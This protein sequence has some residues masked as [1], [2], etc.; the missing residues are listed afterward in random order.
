ME[1]RTDQPSGQQQ[2]VGTR[3]EVPEVVLHAL[4]LP[5]EEQEELLCALAPRIVPRLADTGRRDFISGLR[6]VRIEAKLTTPVPE[7]MERAA[8]SADEVMEE[9]L[10]QAIGAQEHILHMLAT[11]HLANLDAPSR[12]RLIDR[13]DGI[14]AHATTGEDLPTVH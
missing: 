12:D 7:K 1:I 13:L 6:D 3:A 10:R 2:P 5:M 11:R 14:L 8:L 9:V 4:A